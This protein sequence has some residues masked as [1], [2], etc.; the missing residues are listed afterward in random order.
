MKRAIVDLSSVIWTSLLASK[1]K[2]FGRTVMFEGKEVFIN[3]AAYGFDN[4]MNHI[5]KVLD[6]LKLTPRQLLLVV[7]GKNSKGDR[8]AIHPGYKAGR[9]KPPEQYEQFNECK[10]MLLDALISVGATACWQD[11]GVESDDVIGYLAQN[12]EGERWIVSYDKDLAQVVDPAKGI[13]HLRNGSTNQNPFG[14]FPHYLIPVYIAL[15]GDTGD[16]IPGAKDFGATKFALLHEAFGNDGLELMQGLILSKDMLRLEEDIPNC[17]GVDK[18]GR[19]AHTELS[20]GLQKLIDDAEG[21]YLSYEL[22]RLRTE[23][24]NT[25][26]RPL[27]WRVGMVKPRTQVEDHRLRK[28]AGV[29][30]IVSAE[31]YAEAMEWAKKQIAISP[32]VSLD[33][34]ASTPEESDEWLAWRGKE[35]RIDTFGSKLTSLQMTFGPNCQYTFYLPFD[36]VETEGC[37]N[38]TISQIAAFVDL[39]PRHTVTYIQNVSYELPICYMSWGEMWADDPLY[40]GFLRNVRDTAIM[41]SYVDENRP[42]GLKDNSKL[43]LNYEQISYD[44]VTTSDELRENWD[45]VGKVVQTYFEPILKDTEELEEVPSDG[46]QHIAGF[47][48]NGEPT[49]VFVPT[50]KLVP[51]KVHV[52]DVEHLIVKRKMNELTA[53]HVM[54][55]GCDDTICTIALSNYYRVVMELEKTH[56]VFEEVETF[57][58]YLTA[59]AYVQGTNFSLESMAAQE[60]DDDRAFAE[61]EP[62]LMDY[63]MKIGFEGTRYVPITDLDP[64]SIKRAYQVIA[65]AEL[66]GEDGTPAR[67][68]TT[69]K[70]IKLIEL[71]DPESVLPTLITE[72]ALN[73][74]NNMME[75]KF[76]GKPTL[77]LA[78]P[79]QMKELLYD[80][81]KLPVR[82]INDITLNERVKQLDL[83]RAVKKFKA[84]RAGKSSEPLTEVEEALMR[85]KAKTDDDAIRYAIKFDTHV[86]NEEAREAL[87][88]L[89]TMK[90]VMTMR[91]LYYA[92]YWKGLHWKDGKMH[93]SHNQCAAVSR[94]YSMSD[95]NLNQL[96]KHGTGVRFRG[97]FLPHKKN[98]VVAS[99]DFVGQE[100]R[101]AADTSQDKNMLACYVGDDLKDPHSL[102][103]AGALRSAWGQK[104]VDDL[105]SWYGDD[106]PRTPEGTYELFR[107]LLKLPKT[108]EI[109]KR[110]ADHRKGAKNTNFAAQNGARAVKIS[111]ME[112]MPMIEAQQFLDGREA[113]FPGVSIAAKKWSEDAQRT[114]YATTYMGVRRH[115]R[116]AMLSDERGAADRAGRQAWSTRIQASAA[117]MTKLAMGRLWKSGIYFRYDARF[118]AVIHDEL[119]SSVVAEH[120]VEFLREKNAAMTAPYSTMKVPILGSISIGP[121]FAEQH[122]C[123]DWFIQE[124]IEKAL[125]DIFHKEVLAA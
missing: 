46:G 22:G 83:N 70:L 123:G 13:N 60:K 16:K 85:K 95:Q 39:V 67:V 34:E 71:A 121:N 124:R 93:A 41:S 28:H 4:A 8:L 40:H 118:I 68:R 101:L 5:E 73:T 17:M 21:V 33:I 97:H 94:R 58:A 38:L 84:I 120:T 1:D 91:S 81:M 125:N 52:G 62:I 57:P 31:N 87:L 7:E 119:V 61:A 64:A 29:N 6:D 50:A 106:L 86:V 77:D 69:S 23:R 36:N 80:Y 89:G 43:L 18:R 66:L 72:G 42:K 113:M 116:E 115:L 122:E 107:R 44:Q 63:L 104:E 19:P 110:A 54:D 20:R 47:D 26:R 27:E 96:P 14:D 105:F 90:R 82:L 111:E 9:A 102:T 112:T 79:K 48:D 35:D 108:E 88:A 45:G 117:E 15:V 53:H 56:G 99:I 51:E 75:A 59:L 98:A 100:L 32:E 11:G 114:G 2:E 74:I 10:R 37:T 65:G 55:Y 25:M 12:L 92:N 49:K 30:R 24:V 78:S 109:A 76:E 3:T 103:A